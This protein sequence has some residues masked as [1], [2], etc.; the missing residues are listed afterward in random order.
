MMRGEITWKWTENCRS[1]IEEDIAPRKEKMIPFLF[2]LSD[3]GVSAKRFQHE[4]KFM[5]IIY[6]TQPDSKYT[7]V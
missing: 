1:P 2:S 6:D 7:E 4:V 5:V 3:V